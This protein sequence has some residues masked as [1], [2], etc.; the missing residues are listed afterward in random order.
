MERLLKL[1][2]AEVLQMIEENIARGID[3]DGKKYSYSTKP[4]YR[5]YDSRIAAKLG[6]ANQ[7]KLFK[8]VTG[9]NGNLG[10][11][12]LQGYDA[13]KAALA[14][15][16]YGSFLQWS[17][18]MLRNM[19]VINISPLTG[20]ETGGSTTLGFNDPLEARKA[21]YLNVSGAGRSRKLWKFFGLTAAQESRLAQL[22]G[23]PVT[24]IIESNLIKR[25][26]K[27]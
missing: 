19:N 17:G 18:T 23:K 10:M 6:K 20:N 7:G 8:I 27:S 1:L 9:K 13:Y 4:F 24:Q 22:A 16:A 11:I 3:I 21:F 5:P 12:I 2:G 26:E 14:P 25:I 15:N